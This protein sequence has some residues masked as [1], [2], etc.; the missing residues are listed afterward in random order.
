MT[1]KIMF[2]SQGWVWCAFH[3]KFVLV[4]FIRCHDQISIHVKMAF[5]LLSILDA[6]IHVK[7]IARIFQGKYWEFL[8]S[9]HAFNDKKRT[10][11]IPKKAH[12]TNTLLYSQV[13]AR[14]CFCPNYKNISHFRRDRV[15]KLSNFN[16]SKCQLQ[17]LNTGI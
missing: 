14:A 16:T 12:H 4:N 13:F 2:Y 1:T 8:A 17:V 11:Y 7:T 15:M 3:G 9:C 6:P 10:F 5:Y